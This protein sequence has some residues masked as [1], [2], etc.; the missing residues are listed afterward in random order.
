MPPG[1]R[2]PLG[3]EPR[4]PHGDKLSAQLGRRDSTDIQLPRSRTAE[5]DQEAIRDTAT[6]RPTRDGGRQE[7]TGGTRGPE[8]CAAPPGSPG[9][10][11]WLGGS[12]WCNKGRQAPW[13]VGEAV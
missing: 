6:E 10:R 7:E 4:G 8:A 9:S 11:M 12:P 1:Q 13:G 3:Q 2:E 5:P